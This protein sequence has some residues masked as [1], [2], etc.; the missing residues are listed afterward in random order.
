MDSN[1]LTVEIPKRLF[2][3][4]TLINFDLLIED[5]D[6]LILKNFDKQYCLQGHRQQCAIHVVNHVWGRRGNPDTHI[7]S[8]NFGTGTDSQTRDHE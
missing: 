7:L 2:D 4:V 6:S 8:A 1:K 5:K 3:E